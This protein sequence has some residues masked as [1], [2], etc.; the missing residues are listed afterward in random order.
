MFRPLIC[1]GLTLL[2]ALPVAAQ[3]VTNPEEAKKLT[4][5][6]IQGEYAGSY[7]SENGDEEKVGIQIIALGDGKF[8]AVGH[9][10][11]LPGAGWDKG[12]KQEAEGALKRS[13]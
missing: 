4:D 11:G 8:R 7:K 2:L 3:T 9:E 5:Y 10:G 13:R 1:S 12:D 6:Q